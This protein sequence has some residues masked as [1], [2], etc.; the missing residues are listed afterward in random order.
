MT[1]TRAR[2][3]RNSKAEHSPRPG[4]AVIGAGNWGSSLIQALS[5]S[6]LPLREIVSHRASGSGVAAALRSGD[7][8]RARS[9][10]TANLDARI[11][12]ICAPDSSI[13]ST[14]EAIV[15]R[16]RELGRSLRGQIVVHSSGALTVSVLR[17][18]LRAGAAVASIHPVM[19]FPTRRPVPLDGVL[20]GVE[21][22]A[23]VRPTLES[24]VGGLGGVAFPVDSRR[25][26][27]YHAAGVLAS[28]LL[29][30]ALMAALETAQLAGLSHP[31]ALRL[32][33]ALS[34]A[35]ARNFF[36]RGPAASFSG[37]LARG[38][39]STIDL[40]L[41]ALSRHPM[42]GEVYVAL[43]RHAVKTLPVRN[44]RQLRLLLGTGDDRNRTRRNR[45][46]TPGSR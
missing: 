26:P 14:A 23:A 21:A 35:S 16:C 13:E 29:V 24:L 27:L 32:V 36:A 44:R 45:L 15:A 20:F 33:E 39:A 5:A 25:K 3:P 11:L 10:G 4:V 12:W 42:L 34:A 2:R 22:A 30:S 31:Q 38:D 43:A 37:P 18:A 7:V 19:S 1:G 17:A 8:L 46:K 40:H 9:V 6:K 41:R 28:P